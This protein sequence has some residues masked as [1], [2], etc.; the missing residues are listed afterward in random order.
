MTK[1]TGPMLSLSASGSIYETLTFRCGK[2]VHKK[3]FK[4]RLSQE[5]LSGQ[6]GLFILGASVWKDEVTTEQKI[7]WKLL[8]IYDKFNIMCNAMIGALPLVMVLAPVTIPL[9]PLS[10][11]WISGY[12]VFMSFFLVLRTNGWPN[13]PGPPPEDWKPPGFKEEA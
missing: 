3:K 8:G 4:K 10:V 13:Y 7:A 2:Y 1:V 5:E 9:V 11:G 12:Q 6:Q